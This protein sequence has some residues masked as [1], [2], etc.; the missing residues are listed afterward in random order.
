MI[1]SSK[2]SRV[3]KSIGNVFADIGLPES[4]QELLKAQLTM[5]VYRLIK[6]RG[7]TQAEGASLLGLRDYGHRITVTVHLINGLR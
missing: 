2:A 3:T 7:L 1:K 4:D 5:Q 6:S